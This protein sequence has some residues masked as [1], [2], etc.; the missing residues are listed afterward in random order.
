MVPAGG[1]VG[2]ETAEIVSGCARVGQY[3][4][5]ISVASISCDLK[6][7]CF[8]L[9]SLSDANTTTQTPHPPGVRLAY[10]WLTAGFR[11]AAKRPGAAGQ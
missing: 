5:E 9:K 1:A 4:V 2:P 3:H 7:P 11:N 6:R 8:A 10:R